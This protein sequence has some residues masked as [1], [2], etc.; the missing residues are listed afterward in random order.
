[1]ART[2]E[3]WKQE[4]HRLGQVAGRSQDDHQLLER[5]TAE[6]L[7]MMGEKK[8]WDLRREPGE[9]CTE[10]E[11]GSTGDLPGRGGPG[12]VADTLPSML[13]GT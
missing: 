10:G 9:N 3:A 13:E 5:S 6:N 8:E 7:K 2:V 11:V 1:M 12:E 4:H